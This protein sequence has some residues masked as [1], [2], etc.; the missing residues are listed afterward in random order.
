MKLE[1]YL[2]I[3]YVKLLVWNHFPVTV[4]SCL[5][6]QCC[7]YTEA[8]MAYFDFAFKMNMHF[9]EGHCIMVSETGHCFCAI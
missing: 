4:E 2:L 1:G 3:L 8:E 5:C 6:S 7:K 9:V